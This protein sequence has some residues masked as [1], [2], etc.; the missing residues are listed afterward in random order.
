M[1]W[2]ATDRVLRGQDLF[3]YRHIQTYPKLHPGS[4]GMDISLFIHR[5]ERPMNNTG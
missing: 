3:L 5:Q 1:R 2:R 4:Y